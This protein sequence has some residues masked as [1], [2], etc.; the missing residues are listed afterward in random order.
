MDSNLNNNSKEKKS[1]ETK[2]LIMDTPSP[3]FEVHHDE[4][5]DI[6]FDLFELMK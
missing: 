4:N 6:F 5:F 2:V 1:N 3:L